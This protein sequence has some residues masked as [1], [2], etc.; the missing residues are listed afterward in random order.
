[1]E[2]LIRKYLNKSLLLKGNTGGGGGHKYIKREGVSGHYKYSYRLPDGSF[3]SRADL[4]AATKGKN[5]DKKFKESK[6]STYKDKIDEKTKKAAEEIYKNGGNSKLRNFIQGEGYT[7]GVYQDLLEEFEAEEKKEAAAKKQGLSEIQ[8]NWDRD[9]PNS[10]MKFGEEKP[11]G[12]SR[13]KTATDRMGQLYREGKNNSPEMDEAMKEYKEAMKEARQLKEKRDGENSPSAIVGQKIQYSGD[14]T[15]GEKKN[16]LE[17]KAPD[18]PEGAYAI[19]DN[20][21]WEKKDSKWVWCSSDMMGDSAESN[22]ENAVRDTK[23]L[24]AKNEHPIVVNE[25]SK[26]YIRYHNER[27]NQYKKQLNKSIN[28]AIA[29]IRK[30]IGAF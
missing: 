28:N 27:K 19:L 21:I 22:H 4:N 13:L 8:S 2:I 20:E 24:F 10:P 25:L 14:F 26:E 23:E 16:Y 12:S 9:N 29:N 7:I 3:G 5:K 11:S 30:A 15:L 18:A 17:Q 1:M 6:I